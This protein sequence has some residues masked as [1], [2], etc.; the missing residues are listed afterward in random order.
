MPGS[1]PVRLPMMAARTRSAVISLASFV[2]FTALAEVSVGLRCDPSR[3]HD[4]PDGRTDGGTAVADGR[5]QHYRGCVFADLSA[6]P[7]VLVPDRRKGPIR[8]DA[9]AGE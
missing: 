4:G 3:D 7:A 2:S 5:G 9:R 8:A 1:V 6:Q